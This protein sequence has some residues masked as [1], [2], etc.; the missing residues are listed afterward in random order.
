MPQKCKHGS[1]FFLNKGGEGGGGWRDMYVCMYVC[2]YVYLYICIH[3]YRYIASSATRELH[4]VSEPSVAGPVRLL[5]GE[6]PCLRAQ[7]KNTCLG[8]K[9]AAAFRW[10]VNTPLSKSCF[11]VRAIGN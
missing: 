1:F 10:A 8:G 4:R 3:I 2:M 7:N 5:C 6:Q 11:G 9:S